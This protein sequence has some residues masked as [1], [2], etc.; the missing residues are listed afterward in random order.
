MRELP[1]GERIRIMRVSKGISQEAI[2][3]ELGI[4]QAAFSKMERGETQVRVDTLRHIA[5][6]LG[7]TLQELL[8]EPM[9]GNGINLFGLKKFWQ[10]IKRFFPRKRSE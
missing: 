6:F 2:A 4:S 3:Y 10:R 1:V 9:E 7:V 5:K 8:P